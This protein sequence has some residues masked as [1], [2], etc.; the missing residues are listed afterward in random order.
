MANWWHTGC[1]HCCSKHVSTSTVPVAAGPELVI[2]ERPVQHGSGEQSSTA[3][4]GI[5]AEGE[6][7]ADAV[8]A[9]ASA[10]GQPSMLR[11]SGKAHGSDQARMDDT[12]VNYDG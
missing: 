9:A 3:G 2:T 6:G 8:P 5:V 7:A 12:A 1:I 4:A 10:G 11:S